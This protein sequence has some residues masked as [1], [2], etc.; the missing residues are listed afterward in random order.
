MHVD[1][2]V[3]AK[4]TLRPSSS[5]G[6]LRSDQMLR[7]AFYILLNSGA[8]SA[9]GFA[10]WIITARVFSTGDVGRASTLISAVSL[11]SFIGMLGLNTTFVRYLPVTAEWNRL[12]TAGVT[13]VAVCSGAVAL[14]YVLATPKIAPS[15]AFIAHSPV[16]TAGFVLITVATAVNILT[17]SV[18]IAAGKSVY[19]AIVDG[20]V[21]GSFRIALVA[22]FAGGGTFAVFGVA[23]A[24]YVSAAVI[25]LILIVRVFKWRPSLSN[26]RSVLRPVIG[27]SGANYAGNVLNYMPGF[28]V[29]LII[30]DRLGADSEAYYY[31][32]FQ[33]AL[34]LWTATYAVEQAFLAEGAGDGRMSN[35]VL[36]RSLRILVAFCVPGLLALV[37]VSHFLLLAFGARYSAHSEGALLA[38]AV[39]VL[40]IAASNW[41]L[42]VLR[43]ANRLKAIVWSNAAYGTAVIGL[44]WVLA[45][46]GL[47]AVSLS[48]PIGACVGAIVAGVPAI[49]VL[50]RN[51]SRL[52]ANLFR[53]RVVLNAAACRAA[54]LRTRLRCAGPHSARRTGAP[55]RWPRRPCACAGL[56]RQ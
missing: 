36:A 39:A 54:R 18:F 53:P 8:Q 20:V 16:L 40:P 28:V 45:P 27:F 47:T 7:N 55:V 2:P 19:N 35:A 56:D 42:T 12:V 10:F 15:V 24:G 4:I 37:F 49:G 34:L 38:L 33:L 3:Q 46:H 17:D 21:S 30:L 1:Q 26:S 13:L 31:V 48:W 52:H 29:P 6:L 32:A 51:R 22:V 41:F 5:R 11:L 25:S 50:R 23:S 43:L 14:A 44:A 9:L